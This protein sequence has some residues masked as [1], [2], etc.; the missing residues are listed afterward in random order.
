MNNMQ[1][2]TEQFDGDCMKTQVHILNTEKK[3]QFG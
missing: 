1:F 2:C 3:I